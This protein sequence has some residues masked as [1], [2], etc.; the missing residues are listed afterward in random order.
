MLWANNSRIVLLRFIQYMN[1]GHEQYLVEAIA[2]W[3]PY[4]WAGD[5]QRAGK[6]LQRFDSLGI[7][8]NKAIKK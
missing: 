6:T 2:K 7:N 8:F 3:K 1:I 4:I 5:S